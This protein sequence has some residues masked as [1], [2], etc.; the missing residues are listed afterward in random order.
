MLKDRTKNM[1]VII[2][3]PD[4]KTKPVTFT[5]NRKWTH[6]KLIQQDNPELPKWLYQYIR[7]QIGHRVPELEIFLLLNPLAAYYYAEDVI[8]GRWPE[9]EEIIK[10][11]VPSGTAGYTM[12]SI[13]C[14]YARF[15]IKGRWP[16]AEEM[17]L[18]DPDTRFVY[19]NEVIKGRW[20]EAEE[21]TK[22][23]KDTEFI[24]KYALNIIKGRWYEY[25]KYMTRSDYISEYI[26]YIVKK[27][28]PELE[29]RLKENPQVWEGY[30]QWVIPNLGE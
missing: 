9:A 14:D 22:K 7:F 19:C 30:K 4:P 6:G 10:K 3:D 1:E 18:K 16:E 28:C 17:I 2:Y 8:Q 24:Y 5:V 13:A 23:D 21:E 15:V 25:E 12:S 29:E 27:R 26:R 11:F 20:P